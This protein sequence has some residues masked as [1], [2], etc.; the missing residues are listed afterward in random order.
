MAEKK[1]SIWENLFKGTGEGRGVLDGLTVGGPIEKQLADFK[2]LNAPVDQ[3]ALELFNKARAKDAEMGTALNETLKGATGISDEAFMASLTGAAENNLAGV[4]ADRVRGEQAYAGPIVEQ[5]PPVANAFDTPATRSVTSEVPSKYASEDWSLPEGG[6][7]G[8]A[9][10]SQ[11]PVDAGEL[12]DG[13]GPKPVFKASGPG[14]PVKAPAPGSP[15]EAALASKLKS[16]TGGMGAKGGKSGGINAGQA[17]SA[18]APA[19]QI[20]EELGPV[21]KNVPEDVVLAALKSK[22]EGLTKERQDAL[23]K[24]LRSKDLNQDEKM[25]LALISTLPA[26][27]GALGGGLAAGGTGAAAGLAGGLQGSAQGAGIL[28]AAKT[29]EKNDALAMASELGARQDKND[30][31]IGARQENLDDRDFTGQQKDIDRKIGIDEAAKDRIHRTSERSA[32]DKAAMNRLLVGEKAA[33]DRIKT[34]YGLKLSAAGNTAKPPSEAELAYNS[35]SAMFM[36]D[37]DTLQNTVKDFG[38][39]ESPYIGDQNARAI[40]QQKPEQ[41]AVEFAKL[42]DPATAA[43]EGEVENIRKNILSIGATT[44]VEQAM[45][46]LSAAREFVRNHARARELAKAGNTAAEI[47]KALGSPKYLPGAETFVSSASPATGQ[48]SPWSKGR[49]VK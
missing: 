36:H 46:A 9:G 23:D 45:A 5:G 43:R 4:K 14:V 13:Y 21:L 22:G 35:N 49:P 37:I 41:L 3:A 40:L 25:A 48:D 28:N 32:S 30:A 7:S 2:A 47:T 27:L 18:A 1:S 44:S 26:L 16:T 19:V 24:A 38:T 11:V 31:A 17:V 8:V 33:M 42:I 29:E 39:F 12:L 10:P 6:V 34:E 20:I 15:A